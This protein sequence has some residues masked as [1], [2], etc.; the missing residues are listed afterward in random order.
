MISFVAP[1]NVKYLVISDSA[2]TVGFTTPTFVGDV[3]VGFGGITVEF[4]EV[5]VESTTTKYMSVS[6][7]V[8]CYNPKDV[9]TTAD[10]TIVFTGSGILVTGSVELGEDVGIE[11]GVTG[12]T[13]AKVVISGDIIVGKGS[14]T[15]TN[16]GTITVTGE[17]IGSITNNGIINASHYQVKVGV[18]TIDHYTTFAK[19]VS[20]GAKEIT[21][22]G[23]ETVLGTI[24]VP[25][26]VKVTLAAGSRFS[27]GDAENKD[28]SLLVKDRATVTGSTPVTVLGT[29]V[30]ENKAN[31]KLTNV[32]SDVT[33]TVGSSIKYT[34]IYAALSEES[35]DV[36]ISN[37]VTLDKS[38]SVD[39]GSKL[40][41]PLGKTVTLEDGVT[42]TVDGTLELRGALKA[43]SDFATV[44]SEKQG[45][46]AIIV[47]GK[48]VSTSDLAYDVYYISGAVY[49]VTTPEVLYTITSVKD[50]VDVTDSD[51]EVRG[52]VTENIDIEIVK[53]QKLVIATGAKVSLGTI[54]L[55]DNAQ[56]EATG[57]LDA[58]VVTVSTEVYVSGSM[59]VVN[60]PA[61]GIVA[62]YTKVGNI[63]G[64]LEVIDGTLTIND[65]ITVV[66]ALVI[67]DG[68]ELVINSTKTVTINNDKTDIVIDG[69]MT[70][71]GAIV[72]IDTEQT[73]VI[74]GELY[75]KANGSS[76][77]SLNVIGLVAIDNGM[78]LTVTND[79][80]VGASTVGANGTIIG[81]VVAGNVEAYNDANL[82]EAD[83]GTL[84]FTDFYV[85]DVLFVTIF[86]NKTVGQAITTD[87][88][89]QIPG[90][91]V[92]T[93]LTWIKENGTP[94]D[95]SKKIG[96]YDALYITL[97]SQAVDVV[98]SVE[99]GIQLE[100]DYRFYTETGSISLSA[101]TYKV[102]AKDLAGEESVK[103][104]MVVDGVE[105]VIDNGEIT[106]DS[107][108]IG[109]KV[110]VQASY[111]SV[112]G[113]EP[114]PVDPSEDY[115]V[116][117]SV[118]DN[119]KVIVSVISLDGGYLVAGT[120]VEVTFTTLVETVAFGQTIYKPTPVTETITIGDDKP[121]IDNSTYELADIL[122]DKYA[123]INVISKIGTAGF[124]NTSL[125]YKG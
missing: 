41:V 70:V 32:V 19:A 45:T 9:A 92:P 38:I 93:T 94:A 39:A 117:T 21:V 106:I 51:V 56:V 30:F 29:L 119:N 105:T 77:Y 31:N 95:S 124:G 52:N 59:D 16:Q 74:E 12:T 111:G 36:T 96:Y 76:F 10:G 90:V 109:K 78:F 47:N 15:N 107:K 54:S 20:A 50:A 63:V 102:A 1:S 87:D 27:I 88:L 67:A 79:L 49:K 53:D 60:V 18:N 8:V 13:P 35:A 81:K 100:L 46:S 25:A 123:V 122:G 101:G 85:N 37:N 116:S 82:D 57:T 22:N 28:A 33:V 40:T 58:T 97:D 55:V 66:G 62:E 65:D 112:P 5:K 115:I 44:A 64:T 83:F 4:S 11:F 24:E 75:I 34:N 113:P 89:A 103:I 104:I 91:V 73:P 26:E 120:E 43:D 3:K 86:G 42:L 2:N 48:L 99:P 6:G 121:T 69:K 98:I 114:T 84:K 72:V 118:V 110:I 68:A 108:M 125:N 14:V 71:N 61:A 17:V 7:S 80:T 23:V